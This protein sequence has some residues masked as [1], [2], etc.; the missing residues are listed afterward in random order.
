M[1][2]LIDYGMGNLLNVSK[3]VEAAGGNVRIVDAPGDIEQ[4]SAL[5]LPGVGNFGNGMENLR[6]RG[7]IDPIVSAIN[8]KKPFLGICLG[9]QMLFER[10]EEA[11]DKKGLGVLKGKVVKFRD[12]RLKVPHMGWNSVEFVKKNP[13]FDGIPAGSYFYFVHSY[14]VKPTDPELIIGTTNYGVNFTACLARDNILA[15]QF[16]P[17]KSQNAGLQIL[18][19]FVTNISD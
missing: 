12:K 11:P 10:S 7:L 19:N 6:A 3:A 16:H 17:E 9:L 8:S 13:F 14:Y 1:I 15:T 4:A 18:R 5:V 2:A